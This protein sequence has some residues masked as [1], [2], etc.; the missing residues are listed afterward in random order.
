MKR[1]ARILW[2][3]QHEFVYVLNVPLIFPF[4]GGC[5]GH[6]CPVKAFRK[7]RAQITYILHIPTLR[8]R[9]FLCHP[10]Q[11]TTDN[12]ISNLSD[13]TW[14]SGIQT[15]N[16]SLTDKAFRKTIIHIMWL[17]NFEFSCIQQ[18]RFFLKMKCQWK[19]G[20]NQGATQYIPIALSLLWILSCPTEV[21]TRLLKRYFAQSLHT[22]PCIAQQSSQMVHH[23]IYDNTRYS[24]HYGGLLTNWIF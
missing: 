20:G 17:Y 11:I 19:L 18:L 3:S 13:M 1:I 8:Y 12:H 23:V 21:D 10:C 15:F 24:A 7:I 14:E 22:P 5:C 9:M 6:C 16:R 2:S 4:C